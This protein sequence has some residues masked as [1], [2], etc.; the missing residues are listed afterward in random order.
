MTAAADGRA[1]TVPPRVRLAPMGL[2]KRQARLAVLFLLPSLIGMILYMGYP[3]IFGIYVSFTDYTAIAEPNWVGLDNYRKIITADAAFWRALRITIL[4]SL[5][6]TPSQ[7]FMGLTAALALNRKLPARGFARTA[8]YVPG[9]VSW[10]AAALLWQTLLD[11]RYGLVNQ[12]IEAVGLKP[13]AWLNKENTVSMFWSIVLIYL[14][15]SFGGTMLIYLAALQDV[16][17]QLYDAAKIDGA[18]RRQR[19]LAVTVP[20]ISPVTL[21]LVVMT[22]LGTMQTFTPVY[23]L[24][25]LDAYNPS[26]LITVPIYVYQTAFA[27]FFYGYGTAIQWVMFLIL[28][29]FSYLQLRLQVF[30]RTRVREEV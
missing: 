28:F 1:R 7:I 16:P 12:I 26:K 17:E 19:F 4:F 24:A 27:N 6:L 8:Y 21:F 14:W 30:G 2:R 5:V 3:I 10:V 11:Y 29:V 13:I 18:N 15:K 23:I 9:I 22:V 25:G 20:A